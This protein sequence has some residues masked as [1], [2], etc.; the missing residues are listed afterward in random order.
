MRRR[1]TYIPRLA[2]CFG[3]LL[4][5]R[6]AAADQ[7]ASFHII[8]NAANPVSALS[9]IEV[10]RLLLKKTTRWENG[11]VVEPADLAEAAPARE[12][13]SEAVH[14]RGPAA[15]KSYWQQQ[16]FSGADVPPPEFS[17]DSDVVAYVKARAGGIGYVSAVPADPGVKVLRLLP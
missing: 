2:L 13:M 10:S 4:V 11:R 16:I 3:L 5:S 6:G 9:R 1:S 14:R 17:S 12:A 8:V 15:I 7:R